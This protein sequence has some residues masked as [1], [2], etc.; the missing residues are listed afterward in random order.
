MPA[1]RTNGRQSA[2]PPLVGIGELPLRVVADDREEVA[3]G[4]EGA[5]A[6]ERDLRAV[7]DEAPVLHREVEAEFDLLARRERRSQPVDAVA[8]RVVLEDDV[9]RR[10]VEAVHV[11][12]APEC[13]HG[14]RA[15][16]WA[17]RLRMR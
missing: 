5:V 2:P 10:K 8:E 7:V 6:D 11:D 17:D 13:S 16:G 12:R 9:V 15:S 1:R 4:E 3:L 14:R